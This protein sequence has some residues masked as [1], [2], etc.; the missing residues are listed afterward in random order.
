MAD[1]SLGPR[2]FIRNS[3]D[4]AVGG[5]FTLNQAFS[6]A[7]CGVAHAFRTQR[8]MKIHAAVAVLALAA[9][10]LLRVDGPSWCAVVVC[11]AMVF[12][13]E[14]F[15]TAIEAVVDLVTD[16]YHDLAKVA[17]DCAAGAVYVC[18]LGAVVVGLVVFVPP[19]LA[20]LGVG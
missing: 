7:R 11:I 4:K 3:H 14:C 15:N 13:A 18:A 20:L 5:R 17:K 12:A 16:Q 9:C 6:C 2:R 10:A 8:N 1:R 19:V